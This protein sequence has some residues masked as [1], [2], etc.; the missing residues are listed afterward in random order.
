MIRRLENILEALESEGISLQRKPEKLSGGIN[1]NVFKLKTT[2]DEKLVLKIYPASSKLDARER[3]VT[4]KTFLELVN[5]HGIS[6]TPRIVQSVSSLNYSLL[7][8]IDGESIKS[9]NNDYIRQIAKFITDLQI[10]IPF[11]KRQQLPLASEAITGLTEFKANLQNRFKS[12]NSV[13]PQTKLDL[14]IQ[15]WIRDKLDAALKRELAALNYCLGEGAWSNDKQICTFASPSDV[16]IHNTLANEKGLFFYDFEYAG[17]DDISKLI[18]DWVAQPNY[19]LNEAQEL[20]LVEEVL[21]NLCNSYYPSDW[22]YRYQSIK[23]LITIKWI[24]IMLRKYKE[25]NIKLVD[26]EKIMNYARLRNSCL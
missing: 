26:W 25:G 3:R 17:R 24:L 21:K 5:D 10:K 2:S 15:G 4:E 12:I 20:L 8:W 7:S 11:Y 16:G 23:N 14:E 9:L 18:A 19:P 13:V 22:I 1:S 6:N